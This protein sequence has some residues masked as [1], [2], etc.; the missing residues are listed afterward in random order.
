MGAAGSHVKR[1]LAF[2]SYCDTRIVVRTFMGGHCHVAVVLQ[3]L[4]YYCCCR[5]VAAWMLLCGIF[6]EVAAARA[7]TCNATRV[8]LCRV[9][10]EKFMQL[11]TIKLHQVS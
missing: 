1:Y 3:V 8:F 11:K 6:C 7:R 2:H 9:S 10:L 5:H 4:L